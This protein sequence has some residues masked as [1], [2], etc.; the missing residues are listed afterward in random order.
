MCGIAGWYRRGGGAA[1]EATI[2]AQCDAIIHRGPDS[3]GVHMDRDVGFGMRRLS[4]ID[5]A[6]GDQPMYT[7]D[8]R[9]AL[10]YNGEIYNY[11]ELRS[12][13]ESQGHVFRTQCDTETILIGFAHWGHNVWAKLDGMFAACLWD[14]RERTLHLAR[15]ALGIK[16]LYLS[17]QNGEI[18]FAS[19]L[20]ALY[21]IASFQ[22]SPDRRA[23]HDFMSFGHVLPPRTIYDKVE[24]LDPGCVLSI[25]AKGER[26]V[27]RFW[28][29]EFREP[30]KLSEG[31]WIEQFR[32]VWLGNVRRHL[33]ADV[34]VGVFLSGGVDSAAVAAA[35]VQSGASGVKAFTIGFADKKFDETPYAAQIA[36]HLGCEHIQQTVEVQDAAQIA[37]A[38]AKCYDEPFADPSAI[39]TY[40][41][42][43]LAARHVKAALGGDGGD[44]LF[45]GYT[46]HLNERYVAA[47]KRWP[48]LLPG[49]AA[50]AALAP[51]LPA[52]RWNDA[53]ARGRRLI[54]DARLATPRQRFFAKTQ[55]TRPDFRARIYTPDF[56]REWCAASEYEALEHECFP[57]SLRDDPVEDFLLADTSIRLPNVMLTKVDRASMAHSLEARVPFLSPRFAEWA[58][59]VPT[60]LKLRGKTGKYLVRKAIAPW[61][62]AGA[63]D[64][65]KQGFSPPLRDWVRG[66]FGA[67]AQDLWTSVAGRD[68]GVLD[69]AAVNAVF[70]DHRNG[71]RDHSLFLYALAMYALWLG[72]DRRR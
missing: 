13:L 70:A 29:F 6:G 47:L 23:I 42:S 31:E 39:P 2:R 28:R 27:R 46:R 45:A 3:V 67:Y 41:L 53:R 59:R 9:Y 55:I 66:D 38:I 60:S 50:A 65:P 37:P 63:L 5:I 25:G 56:Q 32:E 58:A 51:P 33:I 18:A 40:Y 43:Q 30:E 20:K 22:F 7:E 4:I 14:A 8:G 54:A 12:E 1:D 52:S 26:E 11:P 10:V 36:N 16:P 68:P 57:E 44:E 15:D 62:P 21:P 71:A 49:M 48:G 64:R 24:K 61:L 34:E 17:E 69:G 19:E 72:D 35:A